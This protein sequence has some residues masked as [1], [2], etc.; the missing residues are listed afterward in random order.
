MTAATTAVRPFVDGGRSAPSLCQT[1]VDPPPLVPD[2][3][4]SADISPACRS[5]G[6]A[7]V[8]RPASTVAATPARTAIA[9]LTD[10]YIDHRPR[11]RQ[12]RGR[13]ADTTRRRSVGRTATVW[14]KRGQNG[15][16]LTQAAADRPPSRRAGGRTAT[17]W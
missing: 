6:A 15:H 1:V 3:G 14:P 12:D 8:Y 5:G 9:L 2:G 13:S 11:R 4:R 17:V 10:G 7:T 16:R